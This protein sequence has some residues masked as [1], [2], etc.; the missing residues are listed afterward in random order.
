[1][2]HDQDKAVPIAARGRRLSR[3]LHVNDMSHHVSLLSY[4]G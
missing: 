3:T 2:N 4:K 1:M